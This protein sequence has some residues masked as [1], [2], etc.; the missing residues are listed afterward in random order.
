M[1]TLLFLA[2]VLTLALGAIIAL[3]VEDNRFHT[4]LAESA[5]R[6]AVPVKVMFWEDSLPGK[7]ALP[8]T[9]GK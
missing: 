6:M 8:W 3:G 7:P 5:P 9:D 4:S 2:V 1:F